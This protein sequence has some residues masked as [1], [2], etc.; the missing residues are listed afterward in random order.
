MMLRFG[1]FKGNTLTQIPVDYLFWLTCWEVN[2]NEVESVWSRYEVLTFREQMELF[3][4]NSYN[5]AYKYLIRKQLHVVWAARNVF[6]DKRYC[7]R[8]FRVMPSI[9]H[10]RK[11]GKNHTDWEGRMFHKCCWN[12]HT[13]N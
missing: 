4:I 2:E 7:A 5:N 1:K 11:N 9:G 6:K 8:C 13:C 12:H 10:D 3:L